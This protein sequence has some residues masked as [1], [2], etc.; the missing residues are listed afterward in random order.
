M[1]YCLA[2][3]Y[4]IQVDELCRGKTRKDC[5]IVNMQLHKIININ[6]IINIVTF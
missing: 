4:W 1:H 3:E 6:N 2:I 5:L